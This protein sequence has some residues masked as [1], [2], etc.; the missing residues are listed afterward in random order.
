MARLLWRQSWMFGLLVTALAA[1]A[2]VMI[3]QREQ[4]ARSGEGSPGIDVSIHEGTMIAAALSPDTR[5]VAI[6]LQGVL[7]TL[8]A[9][10]GAATRITDDL[11]D[12]RQPAWS[13][14]GKTIAFESS[15]DGLWH[16]WSVAADG[17]GA[18]ALTSGAFHDREPHWSPDGG[19]IAFSSERS[20]NYDIW[21]LDLRTGALRQVT[22]NRANDF[23]PTYSPDGREIAFVSDRTPSPGVYAIAAKG[24]ER[25]V[26][27]ATGTV[28]TPSWSPD[29]KQVLYT[30]AA[31][32]DGALMLNGSSIASGEDVFPFRP[33]W[34][35]QTEFLYTADGK[36]KRRSLTGQT[37]TPVEF[38][39]T[40][41]VRPP[42]YTRKRR[43][44]DSPAPRKALGII[45]PTISP[46]GT[47]IAFA[48]L[49]D[50]W[51]MKVGS[52]PTRLTD[53]PFVEVDP[54]WSRDGAQLVYSSDRA[55]TFD[56]W[57][58]DMRS[59][60]ERRLTSMPGAET[61]AAWAPDGRRIAFMNAF[62]TYQ[63]EIFLVDV[64]SGATRKLQ[65]ATFGPG[66]PSWSPEGRALIVSK[67][68]APSSRTSESGGTNQMFAVT[69][70]GSPGWSIVPF[71][72]RSTGKRSG[73]GPVW[74]PDG[75]SMAFEM[76]NALWVMPVDGT[77]RRTGAP[78]QLTKEP[79]DY[80]SWTGD[81]KRI[82][83]LATD[84][85]ILVS[86]D[87]GAI[88]DVPLDLTWTPQIP[89]GRTVVHAGRLVDGVRETSRQNMDIVV[90]GNRIRAVEPHRADLHT[91]KVVDAAASSVM[92][93]LMEAH[94]HVIKAHGD[95]F[96]RIHLAY[97][98]TTVRSPA[99]LPFD[100]IEE[101]EAFESGRRPG[102]R[103]YA[104]GYLLDGPRQYWEVSTSLAADAQ[105]DVEIER[106]RK[107]QY[108]ML[109]TYTHLPEP[110]R[111]RAVEGAH[112]IGIPVSSHELYP[113]AAF[114]SDSTEHISGGNSRGYSSKMSGLGRAYQDVIELYAKSKITLTP[115]LSLQGI[116]Q[117]K[118]TD[119]TV[120]EEPRWRLLQ[121]P[122]AIASVERGAANPAARERT[123][124]RTRASLLAMS[125]AG[126]ALVSGTDSPLVPYGVSLHNDLEQTVL[127]GLTPYQALRTATV[128]TAALLNATA[129]LGTIEVGKLADM[130]VV[131]GDPLVDIRNARRVRQVIKNGI[132]IPIE[133]LV[134]PP[135]RQSS[136]AAKH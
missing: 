114:S 108:D 88:E 2:A 91:G 124:A 55:G 136:S 32:G 6:D 5:T 52:K 68:E 24:T 43:D 119:P 104:T 63:G 134:G 117:M 70:D 47:E 131:D 71:P 101:R 11:F 99:N 133:M 66:Y 81:S 49:G 18:R 74:S 23:K 13:A 121:P 129:D 120:F 90:E 116:Q 98:I 31:N 77:G 64:Q 16:I 69:D 113:A 78:K 22:T 109:K 85:L 4:T 111:K 122:W 39:A 21:E 79:T 118:D 59:G 115:T 36:I 106:A 41:T 107:L 100:A 128:N 127:A 7:F 76:D 50:L 60:Q 102:P 28:G 34:L 38:T 82:L 75:K 84:H 130:V 10:G 72:D 35:S 20:G 46:D 67:L 12:A 45:K 95:K 97:G 65:D 135:L 94:T 61:R 37:A 123:S 92:P 53:D 30:L 103:V 40:L 3:A 89:G 9:T 54:A 44:F 42:G 110:L 87:T 125:K 86:V 8:P 126:V 15:R 80:L 96:G 112:G 56:L 26:A 33:Q 73:D 19:R 93:G 132:V 57:I 25:L 27:A 48:S 62:G 29:G 14:D 105:I 1:G 58:R 51:L 83:A 17:A